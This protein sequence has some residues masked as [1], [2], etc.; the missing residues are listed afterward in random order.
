MAEL[1]VSNIRRTYADIYPKEYFESLSVEKIEELWKN[2]L[3]KSMCKVIVCVEMDEIVGFGAVCLFNAGR[4][5]ALL[6]FLHVKGKFE[7]KG[8]GRQIINAV[9]SLLSSEGLLAMEIYCV[10]GNHRARGFYEKL[11]VK[12][13]GS[14]LSYDGKST[15]FTN[16]LL[17]CDLEKVCKMPYNNV[18]LELNDEYSRLEELVCG[19]YILWGT[20]TYYNCFMEQFNEKRKPSYVFDNNEEIQGLFING[21]EV[22]KPFKTEIPIIIVCSKY[23]EIEMQLRSLGCENYVGFYPWHRYEQE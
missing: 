17:L 7:G 9:C 11:G 14:F 8:Y 16:R 21:I 4:R 13:M 20:G 22:V 23:E 19:E 12:Y 15:N 2:Y 3:K 1:H 10:E 5:K 6:D 18:R